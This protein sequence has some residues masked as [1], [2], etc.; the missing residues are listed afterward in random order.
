M[1]FILLAEKGIWFGVL[2]GK[3]ALLQQAQELQVMVTPQGIKP[4][5]MS[6]PLGQTQPFPACPELLDIQRT[7]GLLPEPGNVLKGQIFLNNTLLISENFLFPEFMQNNAWNLRTAAES[8]S[9]AVLQL[10]RQH[11]EGIELLINKWLSPFVY[12]E[13]V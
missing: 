7:E 10:Q 13:I 3:K 12:N 11:R 6:S 2:E 4:C 1:D 8:L 5:H 9:P